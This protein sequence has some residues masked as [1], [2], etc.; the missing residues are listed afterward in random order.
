MDFYNSTSQQNVYHQPYETFA[1]V[2]A[3]KKSIQADYSFAP[4]VQ[5]SSPNAT[6]ATITSKKD[7]NLSGDTNPSISGATDTLTSSQAQGTTN[8]LLIALVG[9]IALVAVYFISRP[10]KNE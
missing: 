6:G 2:Y 7:A 1:P 10:K 9:S 8:Y 3:P 5:I 4:T